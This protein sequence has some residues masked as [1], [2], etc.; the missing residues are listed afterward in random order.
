MSFKVPDNYDFSNTG[1]DW[2]GYGKDFMLRTDAVWEKQQL[3]DFFRLYMK[4]FWFNSTIKGYEIIEPEDIMSLY[5]EGCKLYNNRCLG[6]LRASQRFH[7][8]RQNGYFLI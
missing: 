7:A 5:F 8:H 6:R 4:C 2:K 3:R 1:I